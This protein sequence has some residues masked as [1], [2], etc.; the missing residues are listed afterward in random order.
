VTLRPPVVSLKVY[1]QGFPLPDALSPLLVRWQV[2][3]NLNLP[4][5]FILEFRDPDR[6]VLQKAGITIGTPVKLTVLSSEDPA[7]DTLLE[8]EVTAV[9]AE[10]DFT[11]S[12]VLVRGWDK[13]HRLFRGRRTQA[14]ENVT[15]SDVVQR[16]AER[17]GLPAGTIDPTTATFDKVS[18]ANATDWQFLNQLAGEIGYEVGV[19]DGKLDFRQPAGTDT[20][21]TAGSTSTTDPLQLTTATNLLRLRASVTAAEQVAQVQVRSWDWNQKQALVGTA[22]GGTT[23]A[24]VSTDP[25]TVAGLFD[26]PPLIATTT[27]FVD[28]SGVDAAAKA[29]AQDASA[30]FATLEGVALGSP[31][32]RSGA[33]VSLGLV[34]DPFDGKYVLTSTRH[35]FDPEDGYTTSFTVSGRQDRSLLSLASPGASPA[36]KAPAP[37]AGVVTAIVSDLND[38]MELGR[39]K[40]KF[41][42]LSD[43]Y[44][45][46]WARMTQPGAGNAR[47]MVVMPEVG[48]EVLVA[49]E[50]GDVR[51]PFVIGSLYNGQDKPM[52]GGNLF[53]SSG[54]VNRRGF[55]SKAGSALIFFDGDSK[56]GIAL[57]SSDKGLRISMDKTNT[58]IKVSSNGKVEI[59]ADQDVTISTS[60]SMTLQAQ[61]SLKI[62]SSGTLEL[63]G[64][65]VQITSNGPLQV[66]GTPIQLN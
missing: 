42:W 4:D 5:G 25:A 64:A 39:I 51:R 11:G 18:Q 41:P 19:T 15:Y 26:S 7:G 54:A 24:Q 44:D 22:P 53:D 62:E 32:L 30:P 20:A 14:W 60:T 40:V 37:M 8:G 21:P 2:E 6:D 10:Q 3:D 31:K 36:S 55:V 47:G 35:R 43:D 50:M 34:G 49:F 29:L 63:Q 61:T 16:V 23:S 52:L 38:P 57:M 56:E 1:V 9:E 28:Q 12:S 59:Q 13:S 45:T 17:A 46:D 48:D 65:Q 66:Q 33:A 27:P 58:I